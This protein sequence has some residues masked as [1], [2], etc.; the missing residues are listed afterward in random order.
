L[1][2]GLTARIE[3]QECQQWILRSDVGSPGARRN[4][5]MAYDSDRGVTVLF[6]GEIWDAKLHL[7]FN[8]QD[9]WEYDGIQ[10]KPVIIDGPIPPPRAWA[11]MCYDSVRH[12]VVLC[13]GINTDDYLSDTWV[14]RP[15]TPGHG[16]WVQR[17]DIPDASAGGPPR[18]GLAGHAMVFHEALGVAV[19]MG[20][21]TAEPAGVDGPGTVRS[22]SLFTWNG[23]QWLFSG[24]MFPWSY[25]GP[26]RHAMAYDRDTKT[27]MVLG[28]E[29]YYFLG[30]V[31]PVP[32]YPRDYTDFTTSSYFPICFSCTYHGGTTLPGGGTVPREQHAMVYDP[33]RKAIEVVGGINVTGLTPGDP[34]SLHEEL[35]P[36]TTAAGKP[37]YRI[38]TR[39]TVAPPRNRHAMVYDLRRK[40]SVLFGGSQ[41][42][43]APNDETW[44]FGLGARQRVY[45]DLNN[46]GPKSGSIEH[47]FSTLGQA[48]NTLYCPAKIVIRSGTYQEAPVTIESPVDLETVNGPVEIR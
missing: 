46:V 8:L 31:S 9:T 41:N 45:V 23:T 14:L 5:T 29:Y 4:H 15:T 40:T 48:L 10:W 17:P 24:W 35:V 33:D 37:D 30:T 32:P 12:E 11:A 44:E 16:V 28:G 21:T 19:M 13:G 27:V 47:P 3:A 2:S 18:Y 20:G 1:A 22:S 26:T 34:Q 6:G 42:D 36:F 25:Q 38:E 7:I 43:D 39:N